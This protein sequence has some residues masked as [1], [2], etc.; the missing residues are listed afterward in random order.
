MSITSSPITSNPITSNPTAARTTDRCTPEQ[1]VT[2]S[3]LGYGVLAGPFYVVASL[4]QALIRDGFDLRRHEWSLLANGDFGWVQVANLVLTGL[5]TV[6]FAIGVGRAVP[7]GRGA[8]W[9]PRLL[10]AYG[11]SLV[12]AGAFREDPALGF[13]SGTPQGAGEISW[14]GILHFVAG[15][16]GFACL[17]LAC[18]ALARRYAVLGR[19]GW[20]AFSALTAVVFLA[21]FAMVASGQGSVVANL[22]FTAAV[23]LVWA[24]MTAV[25]TDL[26]R[27]DRTSH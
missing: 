5:M 15:G 25:A 2:R 19:R 14:H 6:A 4:A 11:V 8:R 26:Y 7:T 10:A 18:L 24:W 3:L 13:P 22:A 17:A 23:V 12:A 20:A 1:R 21:G 9:A 16:L 27:G